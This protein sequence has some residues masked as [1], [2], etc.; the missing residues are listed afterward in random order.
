MAVRH[1]GAVVY[2][3][4]YQFNDAA[5]GIFSDAVRLGDISGCQPLNRVDYGRYID[6]PLH[7][8][9]RQVGLEEDLLLAY[10]HIE[11]NDTRDPGRAGACWTKRPGTAAAA[12]TS[13]QREQDAARGN[14]ERGGFIKTPAVAD[15]LLG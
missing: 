9:R 14:E 7:E 5:V 6:L 10:Y 2:P 12:G 4:P 8:I 3:A 15:F 13:R 11:K 1:A